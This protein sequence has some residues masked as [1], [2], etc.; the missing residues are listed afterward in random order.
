MR[1]VI[2]LIDTGDG[3]KVGPVYEFI[4]PRQGQG[5]FACKGVK[6][7]TRPVLVQSSQIKGGKLRLFTIATHPVKQLVFD[8]L[9]IKAPGPAYMHFPSWTT[10]EFFMQ[11][12]G[13]KLVPREVKRTRRTIYEWVKTHANN[14]ALDLSVYALA[15]LRVLQTILAPGKFKDLEALLAE[16]R[17]KKPEA[18]GHGRVIRS[19]GVR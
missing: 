2:C 13:E 8:R 4:H 11:L 3:D 1:P 15:G 14:E 17:G 16:T 7:H 9:K 6:F 12:T 10:E 19:H 5:V 18:A